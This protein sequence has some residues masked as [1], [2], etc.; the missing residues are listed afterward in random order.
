MVAAC[1]FYSQLVL[2]SELHKAPSKDMVPSPLL[3]SEVESYPNK[4]S[5]IKT[6]TNTRAYIFHAHLKHLIFIY[7]SD[8][9]RR[10]TKFITS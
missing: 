5:Y 3:G 4:L 2:L 6:T 9:E 1:I 8:Q 10:I 7:L